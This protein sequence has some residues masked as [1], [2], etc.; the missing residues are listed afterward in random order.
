MA[1]LK[2]PFLAPWSLS[3]A[4]SIANQDKLNKSSFAAASL[5]QHLLGSSSNICVTAENSKIKKAALKTAQCILLYYTLYI[6][7]TTST[8]SNAL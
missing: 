2:E 3:V 5:S 6:N 4:L 1:S 8:I 7:D